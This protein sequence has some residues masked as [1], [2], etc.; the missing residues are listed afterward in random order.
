EV[1][2]VTAFLWQVISGLRSEKERSR[3]ADLLLADNI[4]GP[5]SIRLR[6]ANQPVVSTRN[7]LSTFL[8]PLIAVCRRANLVAMGTRRP[9]RSSRRCRR[10]ALK[11]REDGQ[12]LGQY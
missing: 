4:S 10:W 6:R 5:L 8:A 9:L 11:W 3:V 7:A 1:G 2:L 12:L